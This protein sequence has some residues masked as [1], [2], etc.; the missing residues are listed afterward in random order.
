MEEER[1]LFQIL[2]EQIAALQPVTMFGVQLDG[3]QT[4]AG[5]VVLALSAFWGVVKIIA[6]LRG[7]FGPAPATERSLQIEATA[8]GQKVSRVAADS[9][10]RDEETRAVTEANSAKVDEVLALLK[11][12]ADAPLDPASA[13]ALS[14]AL[15]N[16]LSATEGARKRAADKVIAGDRD[17]ALSELA[18]TAAEGEAGARNLAEIQKEIGAL[19]FPDR[20]QDALDAYKRAT[21]LA[22]DDANAWNQ[23]GTLQ[24]RVGALDEAITGY[25]RVLDLSK[26]DE[27]QKAA[28]FNNLGVI[29]RTRGDL[30]VAEDFHKRALEINE[31]LGRLEGQAKQLGNLGIV[32]K[33]R[34]DLD[35]AKLNWRK[36]W[37][38]CRQIG[39]P[40]MEAQLARWLLE[41]G[42]DP[43][44]EHGA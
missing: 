18:Q 27:G 8:L 24:L 16:L 4:F 10:K 31:R 39:I 5:G 35:A 43:Q 14:N 28:A 33:T 15:E 6:T 20:T 29:A 26:D 9:A 12:K 41:I 30:G 21:E 17:G 23:Y 34:G 1:D 40:H 37:A 22:P 32:A 11:S 36:A 3:W 38:L 25:E 44:N 42:V 2:Q 7:A 19:A 13:E